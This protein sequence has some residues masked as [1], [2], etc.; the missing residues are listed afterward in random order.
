MA[1]KPTSYRV[2]WALFMVLALWQ[3]VQALYRVFVPAYGLP[4][5]SWTP[6]EI[7]IDVGIFVLFLIMRSMVG[8]MDHDDPRRRHLAPIFWIGLVSG[9]VIIGLRF[10]GYYPY[11]SG[12]L[13]YQVPR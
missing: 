3:G 10:M 12:H 8:G 5:P 2:T 13:M 6:K 1:E 7:A 9:I 11:W 4:A